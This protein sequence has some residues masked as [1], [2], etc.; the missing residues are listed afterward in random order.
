MH[1]DISFCDIDKSCSQ[2]LAEALKNNH[3]IYGLHYEGNS[4]F[5]D[6]KGYLKLTAKE[7]SQYPLPVVKGII[8]KIDSIKPNPIVNEFKSSEYRDCCWICESWQQVSFKV[9]NTNPEVK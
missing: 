6:G 7:F 4:G 8:R 2:I 5:V 1:V 3:S 9:K